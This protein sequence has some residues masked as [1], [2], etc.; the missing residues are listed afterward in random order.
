MPSPFR[1]ARPLTELSPI[2]TVRIHTDTKQHIRIDRLKRGRPLL[3]RP[4]IIV[5]CEQF[6]HALWT[7]GLTKKGDEYEK[8]STRYSGPSRI[9]G[10]LRSNIL[11]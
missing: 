3:M 9:L 6:Q 10:T 2:P 11:R 5:S 1:A 4:A 8:Y 7:S